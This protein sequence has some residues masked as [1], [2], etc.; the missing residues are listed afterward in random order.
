MLKKTNKTI[1]MHYY[2][3]RQ[4]QNNYKTD[5]LDYNH[6]KIFN[7]INKICV[8]IVKIFYKFQLKIL[9]E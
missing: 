6:R 7:K 4:I 2:L 3:L 9:K 8:A 5:Y 1:K